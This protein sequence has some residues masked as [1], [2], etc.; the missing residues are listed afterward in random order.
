MSY[1]ST[2]GEEFPSICGGHSTTFSLSLVDKIFSYVYRIMIM[3]TSCFM[4][5]CL[6]FLGFKVECGMILF[7]DL[8]T[9]KFL[10]LLEDIKTCFGFQKACIYTP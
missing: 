10:L 2:A 8:F 3:F 4:P 7:I 1:S 6:G 5:G 9:R